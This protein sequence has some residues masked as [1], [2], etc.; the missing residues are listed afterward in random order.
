[1]VHDELRR[2]LLAMRSEDLAFR[3]ELLKANQLSGPYHPRMEAIHVKNAAR[4]RELIAKHGWPCADLAGPDGADAAWLIVQH[5]I[6]EPAFVRRSLQLLRSMSEH[7]RVPAW[8]CA[9]LEDRVALFEGRPQRYGTQW[10][11]DPRDGLSRPWTLAYPD[12][13]NEL[14]AAVGLKPLAPIPSPGPEVSPEVR[15]Q[16]ETDQKWWIDWLI[17]R[18]W[19]KS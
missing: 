4:L 10:L 8:H 11:D 14:R 1:M 19:R 17:S 9:Y 18:G 6:G 12:R 3:E 7:N 5:S 15:Q 16:I 2:E 13:V